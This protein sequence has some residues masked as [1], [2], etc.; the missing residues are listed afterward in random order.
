MVIIEIAGLSLL[1]QDVVLHTCSFTFDPSVE[2]VWCTLSAGA[3]LVLGKAGALTDMEYLEALLKQNRVSFFDTV[4]SVLKTYLAVCSDPFPTSLR[5]IYVGGEA[6][7][8]EMQFK[9][10][11]R[12]HI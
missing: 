6:L 8:V 7:H 11:F 5:T 10:I 3:K 12:R 4:P 9:S 2:L 1:P